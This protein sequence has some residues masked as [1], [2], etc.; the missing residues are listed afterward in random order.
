MSNFCRSLVKYRK[1]RYND[2][3][4]LLIIRRGG[5]TQ[6]GC[7]GP[8]TAAENGAEKMKIVLEKLTK[9]FPGR[10][11]KNPED[12]TAV[13]DFSCEIPDGELI[14]LLGPS[15][16][17]KSTTL[18]LLCGLESPTSGRILFG[19]EDITDLPPELRGVGMVFQNYALYPHLT[20]K[21][22]ILFPLENRKGKDRLS[23]EEMES[24]VMETARL[25]QIEELMDRRPK[26]LSGGQQQRVA[27]AR[28]LVKMPRVLLL[29]EPL[30]NLDAR[31]R[32]KT[33]EEIRK[34]QKKTG[35]TTVFVTH[36]QD[37]AMSISD[38]IAV[39]RLGVL[40]QMGRPQEVYD[41]P[42]NLFVAKFL[43]TPPI[44]VFEGRV[45][46]GQLYIGE[47]AVLPAEGLADQEVFAGIRPE[48]FILQ[49]EG[50]LTCELNRVEIMGRDI[51]VIASHPD[52]AGQTLRAIIGA[53]SKVDTV[54][55]A[56]RFALKPGKVLLFDRETEERIRF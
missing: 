21:Q 27:I 15:G 52:C 19:E 6:E 25:V 49:E 51:S 42:L 48:G 38:R 24:R 2:S 23:K 9:T 50:P 30:S 1:N 18:N 39:M 8:C 53:E 43:G 45:R 7:G 4:R 37:E 56:V 40:M 5:G 54:S 33:R 47:E 14:A 46:D 26:E 41:D 22:N 13:D 3:Q 16:C 12:V 17:G 35:I 55:P 44:N 20:V 29:D 32:L 31:L 34:I 36:D 10:G 11:R 28:A